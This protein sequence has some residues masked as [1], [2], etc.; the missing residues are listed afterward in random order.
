MMLDKIRFTAD[1]MLQS[2]GNWLCLLEQTISHERVLLTR[3]AHL[4]D[5]LSQVRIAH[6]QVI[7]MIGEDLPKELREM[8][9]RFSLAAERFVFTRCVTCRFSAG[10]SG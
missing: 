10:F 7:C 6:R 8:V 2:L 1:G 4:S 5:S 9:A 3:N